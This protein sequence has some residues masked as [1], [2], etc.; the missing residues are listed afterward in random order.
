MYPYKALHSGINM[1]GDITIKLFL[2][3]PVSKCF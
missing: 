3:H 1:D 2:I